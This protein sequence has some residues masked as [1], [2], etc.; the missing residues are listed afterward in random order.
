MKP[1]LPL[2]DIQLPPEPAFWPPAPGWWLLAVLLVIA[3][4]LLARPLLRRQRIAR[5]RRLRLQALAAVLGDAPDTGPDQIA[6]AS[7]FLRRLV[8]RDAPHALGLRDEDWLQFL[9]S[10]LEDRPFTTGE[11]RALLD[12]AYRAALSRDAVDA[13]LAAVR[14]RVERGVA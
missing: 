2:R 13:T 14:R 8:R 1:S 7:E 6:A 10:G 4:F 11:A 3:L 5:A 12:G 9:D